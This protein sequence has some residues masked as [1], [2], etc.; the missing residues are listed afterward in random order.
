MAQG[1]ARGPARAERL[2]P[3]RGWGRE[4]GGDS[5]SGRRGRGPTRGSG[6]CP[7][8]PLPGP[9]AGP[10]C[11]LLDEGGV[12]PEDEQRGRGAVAAQVEQDLQHLGTG[13][14]A[15]RA[16]GQCPHPSPPGGE[17]LGGG[18]VG[19]VAQGLTLSF[20]RPEP[21]CRRLS[22]YSRRHWLLPRDSWEISGRHSLGNGPHGPPSAGQ[23]A[24]RQAPTP[25]P[26]FRS[27]PAG[28][29]FPP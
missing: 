4:D 14:R 27:L 5:R 6:T 20:T 3:G 24:P 11:S 23:G 2:R 17:G 22:R 25:H 9:P 7:G 15:A 12:A 13:T 10:T 18:G 1:G 16:H 19:G 26:A 28:S 21:L 29:W 8:R